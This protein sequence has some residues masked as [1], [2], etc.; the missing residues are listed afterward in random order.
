MSS[1]SLLDG[2]IYDNLEGAVSGT[3][4]G[5][6]QGLDGEVMGST[7]GG[8]DRS[9]LGGYSLVKALGEELGK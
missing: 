5:I 7:H 9:K 2:V 6:R 3:E 8:S 4:I 1:D